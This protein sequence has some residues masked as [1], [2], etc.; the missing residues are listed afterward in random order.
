[1]KVEEHLISSTLGILANITCNNPYN[2][3]SLI[4]KGFV[5]ILVKICSTISNKEIVESAVATLRH[6]TCRNPMSVDACQALY[7]LN[8]LPIITNIINRYSSSPMINSANLKKVL[9]GLI[10]N[11]VTD[12]KYLNQIRDLKI[13]QL[14]AHTMA[15][16]IEEIK[17]NSGGKSLPPGVKY[18]TWMLYFHN[19][20]KLLEVCL[21]VLYLMSLEASAFD[22]MS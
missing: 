3:Q 1:M 14:T 8:G 19:C 6:L 10:A 2:K 5:P 11:F 15:S 12:P 20:Q 9:F 18:Y 4:S 22:L 13:T 16:V 21:L 7:E 17:K